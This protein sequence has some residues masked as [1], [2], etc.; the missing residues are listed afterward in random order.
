MKFPYDEY[1][2]AFSALR[3]LA[4]SRSQV[5]ALIVFLLSMVALGVNLVRRPFIPDKSEAHPGA[6]N[7]KARTARNQHTPP[8]LSKYGEHLGGFVARVR[9][10]FS[11]SY[12]PNLPSTRCKHNHTSH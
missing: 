6:V 12:I 8:W 9:L 7:R 1:V 4:L 2:P 10:L 11:L 3:M 5:F